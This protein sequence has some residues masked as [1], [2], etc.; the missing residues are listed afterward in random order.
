MSGI[1]L[2]FHYQTLQVM[3]LRNISPFHQVQR[4][5]EVMLEA[6]RGKLEVKAVTVLRYH[7]SLQL[8]RRNNLD[9]HCSLLT[10]EIEKP[11]EVH[12][13]ILLCKWENLRWCV[14]E[15]P[16]NERLVVPWPVSDGT[17]MRRSNFETCFNFF[18]QISWNVNR[19][20]EYTTL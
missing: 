16:G 17:V 10:S 1:Q 3:S 4:Q 7:R 20:Y 2:V 18:T 8:A 9:Q 14:L 11:S 5:R 19:Y 6:R 12:W 13:S 15:L